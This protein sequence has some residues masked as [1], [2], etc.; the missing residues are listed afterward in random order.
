MEAAIEDWSDEQILNELRADG[1][2]L[3]EGREGAAPGGASLR[4]T[5]R[6]HGETIRSVVWP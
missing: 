2:T 1:F 3:P 5:S 6:Q 4:T